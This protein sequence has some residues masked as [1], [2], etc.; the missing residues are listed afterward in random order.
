M[1]CA[2][3]QTEA[4]QIGAFWI[5]SQHGQLPEPKRVAPMRIFL[6]YGHD[7]NEELV[8]RIKAD[9]QNRGHDVWFDTSEIKFGDDW[10]RR[11]TEGITSSHKFVSFL[12][13]NSA[14][15]SGVCLDEIG[16]AIGV[17]E[18]HIQTV[19]VESDESRRFASEIDTLHGHLK[20]IKSDA[21][22]YDLLKKG[23]F[24]H[25]WLFA[26]VVSGVNTIVE[27]R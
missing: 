10:R 26:A 24:G 12:T 20:P 8:A 19:L 1:K 16:N 6:S 7:A 15:D 18:G 22:I 3:C 17:K 4:A 23:F 13:N 9:L 11:I 2:Q 14:R 5:C 21:C 25:A 27:D